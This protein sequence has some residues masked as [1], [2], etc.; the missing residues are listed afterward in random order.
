MFMLLTLLLML[1]REGSVEVGDGDCATI[2]GLG[3]PASQ[4]NSSTTIIIIHDVHPSTPI[5]MYVR[6]EFLTAVR[7][8][9]AYPHRQLKQSILS[10][11]QM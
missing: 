10:M 8:S 2:G 3:E 6:Q 1:L 5:H 4:Q 11:M 7:A 9:S